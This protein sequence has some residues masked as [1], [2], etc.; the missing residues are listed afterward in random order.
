MRHTSGVLRRVAWI[1]GLASLLW[2]AGPDVE[3]ARKLYNL[4]DFDQSLR[5]LHAIPEK[6]G[7]VYELM[8]RNYY[9]QGEYKKATE[10]LEKA[11]AAEPANSQ[12]ALWLARAFGR[13]AETS[14]PFTAPGQASRARQYFEKAAQLNP[15]NLDALSDLFEY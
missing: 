11:V 15:R 4:T 5:V 2:A 10:V 13:R 12:Y 14:S 6:N 8:G 1:L 3:Q 7:A 9:M